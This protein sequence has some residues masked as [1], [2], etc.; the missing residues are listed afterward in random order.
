MFKK[1]AIECERI[2]ENDHPLYAVVNIEINKEALLTWLWNNPDVANLINVVSPYSIN[3][4]LGT[5][6]LRLLLKYREALGDE[7]IE[8]ALRRNHLFDHE[9]RYP[10]IKKREEEFE[11]IRRENSAKSK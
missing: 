8:N 1:Y 11:R 10:R 7:N 5:R 2:S 3:E 9:F 4:Q 6:A